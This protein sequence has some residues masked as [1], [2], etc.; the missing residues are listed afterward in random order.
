MITEDLLYYL[1]QTK[2][3]HILSSTSGEIIEILDY[4]HRNL[5][6]GPDFL[7]A[8]IRYRE[9]IWA[10]SV[11]MHVLNS[12]WVRHRHQHD[13]AFLNVVLHL[14]Y[15]F[16]REIAFF[17]DNAFHIPVSEI[18][19][20]INPIHMKN[21]ELLQQRNTWIP[22][23]NL[24]TSDLLDLLSLNYSKLASERLLNRLP[25]IEAMFERNDF[26]YME[27]LYQLIAHYMGGPQNG[28]VFEQ[29]AR[30]VPYTLISKNGFDPERV[31]AMVFGTSSLL[32]KSDVIDDFTENLKRE[33]RIQQKKYGFQV[34][35]AGAWR[36]AGMMPSGQPAFRLAQWISI[37]LS[38]ENMLSRILQ[39]SDLKEV[40]GLFEG[41]A[42]AYW[43]NHFLFGRP[44]TEHQVQI[45]RSL[46]DRLITNAVVPFLFFYGHRNHS[47][48][49]KEKAIELLDQMKAEDNK[50]ISEWKKRGANCATALDSQA[51]LQLKENHCSKTRCLQCAVGSRIVSGK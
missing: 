34:I 17:A 42:D 24:L 4:G 37:I 49:H 16:D 20:L 48:A 19:N 3:F 22:C 35:E 32:S 21:H 29:L 43:K 15:K 5:A 45:T 7:N 12:D 46:Q 6:S 26:D 8:K 36:F 23:E 18:K 14:V 11:E 41:E 39:A 44:T 28:P 13:A 31:K 10:G 27:T 51:L 47:P 1:W 38:A 40:R 25:K 9:M 2:K 33:F 50:V 30:A